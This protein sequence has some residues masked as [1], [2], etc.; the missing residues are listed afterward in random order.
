MQIG[1]EVHHGKFAGEGDHAG[2]A[3]RGEC[4][5]EGG[6]C[7]SQHVYTGTEWNHAIMCKIDSRLPNTAAPAAVVARSNSAIC[8]LYGLAERGRTEGGGA[9]LSLPVLSGLVTVIEYVM[10][11]DDDSGDDAA[12]L[13]ST[14][15]TTVPVPVPGPSPGTNPGL[16]VYAFEALAATLA[17]AS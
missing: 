2:L 17:R 7:S 9:P 5:V 14:S 8:V 3:M 10:F 12:Q 4:F 6:F 11:V 16:G 1:R 15:A 13:P